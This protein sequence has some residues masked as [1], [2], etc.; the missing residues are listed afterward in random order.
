[1]SGVRG[2]TIGVVQARTTSSRFPG[3]VLKPL[4]GEPMIL[5]QLERMHRAEMLDLI[6]VA[7]SDQPSDDD[8]STTVTDAGFDLVR[9][10]LDDVLGR[11]IRV[12]DEYQPENVVRF[13][14]DCPLMCPSVIDDVVG[15]FH[16]GSADYVSNT[17][18]PTYPDGLD[19][20]AVTA[21]ALVRMNE[22]STD[23]DE[24]EHVTLGIYRR[25]SDFRIANVVDPTGDNHSA[26]RW[27]VDT[28]DD[29]LFVQD[30]YRNLFP[31]NPDF[32]YGQILSL[33]ADHPELQRTGRSVTR[34]AAL[35][36]LDTGVMQHEGRGS[37]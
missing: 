37:V 12:I 24:R 35:D 1:M 8:L 34:N 25:P 31:S 30:V 22:I 28:A 29:L 3:K 15:S 17:M 6:V 18:V 13:T 26:M 20:E 21:A 2:F 5:R 16:A 36:G 19:V 33:L 10:S 27:T 11:F 32:E 7:T 23:P 14:A 9:G 4:L